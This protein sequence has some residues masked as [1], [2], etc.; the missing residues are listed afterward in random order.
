MKRFV[1]G[2]FQTDATPSNAPSRHH[3]MHLISDLSSEEYEELKGAIATLSRFMH[4]SHLFLIAEW[5]LAEFVEL[6]TSYKAAYVEKRLRDFVQKPINININR[7]FLNLLSSIRSYLDFMQRL[8]KNRFG[9]DS[10]IIHKFKHYCRA[11]YDGNFSYRFLYNLRHYA[12]HKGFPVNSISL[13]QNRTNDPNRIEHYLEVRILR[14]QI[15][16]DFD[17]RTLK[18]EIE[19]LPTEIDVLTHTVAFIE[20]LRRIHLQIIN[21]LFL[22]LTDDATIVL[23]YAERVPGG[24]DLL[25]IFEIDGDIQNLKNVKELPVP[26]KLAQKIIN[27]NIEEIFTIT[28]AV[29]G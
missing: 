23:K 20:S 16:N 28:P 26:V 13:G 29:A 14:D 27:G 10:Q 11:E 6:I 8:L 2:T 17:W 24:E 21:D 9:D 22:T 3:R 1:L 12:Q 7:A 5:N 15:L 4:D 19:K 25:K 18:R